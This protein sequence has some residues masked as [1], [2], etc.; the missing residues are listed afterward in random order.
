MSKKK[1]RFDKAKFISSTKYYIIGLYKKFDEDH[2]WILSS[3]IA[4]NLIICAIPFVL[5]LFSIFGIYLSQ[6]ST[7]HTID[8]YTR[9]FIGLTPELRDKIHSLI[10]SRINEISENR[11]LTALIG[12]IGMLWTASG[13]FSTIRDVLNRI[14][15]TKSQVFYLWGKLKDIGMVFLT[16]LFFV[17]SLV[18]SFLVSLIYRIDEKLLGGILRNLGILH[19]VIPFIVGFLFS[20]L[21]FY[22]IYKLVP[23][24]HIKNKIVFISAISSSILWEIVKFIFTTYL[25]YFSNFK[26]VYGAYAAIVAVIFWIYYSSFTFVVGAEIGQLYNERKLLPN[27]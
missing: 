25:V 5:I 22:V 1:Q 27:N 13:L 16:T 19:F 2:I 17:L 10:F 6:D 14:Y 7:M 26:A 21:M 20:F 15:K 9:N 3:G 24:G 4:F 23:H 12:T 8:H 11:E 18:S